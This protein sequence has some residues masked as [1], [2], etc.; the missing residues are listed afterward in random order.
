MRDEWVL[1]ISVGTQCLGVS[2]R[3]PL[4]LLLFLFFFLMFIFLEKGHEGI[5][6]DC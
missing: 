5:D 3:G 2:F 1:T 4:V 6:G